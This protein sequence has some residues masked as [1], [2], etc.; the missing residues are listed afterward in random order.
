VQSLMEKFNISYDQIG[1]MEVCACM[2][3]I[4]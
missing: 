1:R 4:E 2:L 3:A